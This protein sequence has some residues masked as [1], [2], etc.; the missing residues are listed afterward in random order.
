MSDKFSQLTEDFLYCHHN[1]LLGD[2]DDEEEE[3]DLVQAMRQ[4]YENGVCDDIVAG[5]FAHRVSKEKYSQALNGIP[6]F[7]TPKQTDGDYIVGYGQ[8]NRAIR[9]YIQ[10][11]NAHTLT[12]AGS[13]AGKT[14][15]S[16]FRV[17]QIANKIKGLWLFD[18]Q[19][20]EY[21]P[22]KHL[23]TESGVHLLVL[24][25]R[26]LCI[27]PLQ[28]H[29]GVAIQEGIPRIAGM[30]L[31]VFE[32]PPR[33]SKLLQ[34]K[35]FCLYQKFRPE[36]NLYPTLYD[37]FES[38]KTDKESNP[39]AR[40]SVLDS[41]EPILRSLGPEV[42]AYRYGWPSSELSKRHIC[43]QF[44]GISEVDK[45]LLLNSLILSEFTYRISC[46]ISNPLMDLMIVVDEA[47][48]LCS[49]TDNFSAIANLI[50]LVRG[51]GIG[52][53]LSLQ[54]THSLLPQITSNTAS[55]FLGR[56]GSIADYEAAGRSMGLDAKQIEWAQMNLEPG[57]FVGRFGEGSLRHPFVFRVPLI[58]CPQ[59]ADSG[60][61]DLGDLSSLPTVYASEFDGWGNPSILSLPEVSEPKKHLFEN[62]QEYHFCKAVVNQP[63]QAS[64]SYPKLAGI[65]SKNAKKVRDQLV[66]RA[67][68]REHTFDSGDRGRSSILLEPLPVGIQA[69]QKYEEN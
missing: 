37:L 26:V 57:M 44:A 10:Y 39:Q 54:S 61:V 16:R 32:L 48:R 6:S 49:S 62:E 67:Y 3:K 31:Q 38:I 23:L 45:N 17:L 18:M 33:A 30:L 43:F 52:L 51:T 41:M 40:M 13:G 29:T 25:A 8:D 28:L 64:S 27:N 53:D 2:D 56:C 22:M 15:L 19:K 24:P 20:S 60:Q 46:G 21:A 63:M 14:N 55:K 4:I 7:K 59:L 5:M 11:M 36:K 42:L 69:V 66:S 34:S 9:S 12:I 47:Q 1:G 65:S 50:G 35:L 68:I 58:R